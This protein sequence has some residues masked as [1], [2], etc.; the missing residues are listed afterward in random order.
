VTSDASNTR[1][2]KTPL[3]S[4]AW[5]GAAALVVAGAL[6]T[7]TFSPFSLWWLGPVSVLLILLV[8]VPMASGKL[9]RAGWL[10]GLGLFGSGASW[11]Y[12]SISEHGNTAIPIAI[13]LTVLFVAGLALFHG[14]AFWFWGRASAGGAVGRIR[15]SRNPTRIKPHHS[16]I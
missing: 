7:L 10:T 2:L 14:L 5:L 15:R 4:N 16:R 6:Q 9:F 12:I 8:T 13:L 11:V 1:A 3:S